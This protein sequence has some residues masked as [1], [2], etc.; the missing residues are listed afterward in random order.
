M[1]SVPLFKEWYSDIMG[2]KRRALLDGE[3]VDLGKEHVDLRWAHAN[4]SGL[5]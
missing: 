4:C 2:K 5:L 1:E 3:G